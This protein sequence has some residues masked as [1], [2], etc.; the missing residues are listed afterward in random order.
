MSTYGRI[1]SSAMFRLLT[2][3][4]ARGE[5]GV[6]GTRRMRAKRKRQGKNKPKDRS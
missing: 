4:V 2:R 1:K 3:K 6:A 5:M